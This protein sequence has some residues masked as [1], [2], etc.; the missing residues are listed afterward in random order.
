MIECIFSS[1]FKL[2]SDG[3]T[4]SHIS[5]TP[6]T[7]LQLFC[8]TLF[9]A[10]SLLYPYTHPFWLFKVPTALPIPAHTPPSEIQTEN[11]TTYNANHNI[12]K[13]ITTS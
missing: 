9:G 12:V 5:R 13:C 3:T 4:H 6:E 7:F 8:P 10:G 1:I 11:Q 2:F